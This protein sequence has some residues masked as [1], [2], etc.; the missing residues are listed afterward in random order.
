MTW[1]VHRGS[2]RDEGPDN[3]RSVGG[4]APLRLDMYRDL[5]KEVQETSLI[6]IM[7]Q[8]AYQVAMDTVGTGYVT[9]ATADFAY[10]RL[11]E[12]D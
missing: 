3:G 6:V 10:S 9:G 1:Q 8:A 7:F 11:V 2:R 4:D 12:K 5:Q